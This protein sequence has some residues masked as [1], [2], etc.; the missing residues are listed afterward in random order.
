MLNQKPNT[1]KPSANSEQILIRHIFIHL[2]RHNTH[3][4]KKNFFSQ[5]AT[6]EIRPANHIGITLCVVIV[7]FVYL[8][9]NFQ[10]VKLYGII[11]CVVIVGFAHL[12]INIQI[13]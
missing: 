13:V 4:G 6:N 8:T 10:V 1:Q 9:I 11:L 12:T 5:M 3:K 2:R 7:G